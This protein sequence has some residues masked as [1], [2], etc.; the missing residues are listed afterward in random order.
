MKAFLKFGLA[1]IIVVSTLL[2]SCGKYDDGPKISLASK[3]GRLCRA[4]TTEKWIDGATG[5]EVACTAN[6]G[7]T[8]YK[9][10]GTLYSNGVS[11]TGVTWQFS[12]D[13]SKLETVFGTIIFTKKILR[14]TS[15]ELWLKDE[16]SGDQ[17]HFK[18]I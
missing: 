5:L 4:W 10:E 7:S 8:E 9:K 6:C 12:S 16:A 13:K 2:S 15:K 14:L 17:E 1:A 3:K 11:V 18:A